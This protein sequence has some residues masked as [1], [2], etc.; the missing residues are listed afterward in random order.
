MSTQITQASFGTGSFSNPSTQGGPAFSMSCKSWLQLQTFLSDVSKLPST[1]EALATMMGSGAP[2][3]M[4]DFDKLIKLYVDMQ[5]QGTN[6]TTS[7]YPSIVRLADDIYNY[8]IG[9]NNYYLGLLEEI[10]AL[11]APGITPEQKATC[12][13]NIIAIVDQLAANISPFIANAKSVVFNLN[14]FVSSLVNDSNTLSTYYAYY[15]GEYGT[16]SQAKQNVISEIKVQNAALQAAR[17]EYNHDVIV[18]ATTPTY[19]W[20][21]FY[22]MI[23]AVVVAGVFGARATAALNEIHSIESTINTLEAE[24]QADINLMACLNYTTTGITNLGTDLNTATGI[25]EGIEGNW[26]AIASDLTNISTLLT[27]DF[28]SNLPFLL[29]I[30][31][32]TVI[33]EWNTLADLANSFRTNA[34]IT[35]SQ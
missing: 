8:A 35:V 12:Q 15:N 30:D 5:T 4:S 26:S 1:T 3:P 18:A 14:S 31:F 19:A 32:K 11:G 7:L 16:N 22:G 20:I 25:M 21:P 10:T 33:S 27:T 34:F 13:E 23:A 9:I 28:T 17:S 2:N 29:K 6:F 24:E